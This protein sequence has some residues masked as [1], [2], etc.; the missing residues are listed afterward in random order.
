MTK[1]Q[2]VSNFLPFFIHSGDFAD[3][4]FHFFHYWLGTDNADAPTKRTDPRIERFRYLHGDGHNKVVFAVRHQNGIFAEAVNDGIRHSIDTPQTNGVFSAR[5][6]H[7]ENLCL[8]GGQIYL[9][10]GGFPVPLLLHPLYPFHA[11]NTEVAEAL[12]LGHIGIEIIVSVIPEHSKGADNIQI[13][14]LG[15]LPLLARGVVK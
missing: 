4:L 2:E 13:T 8:S 11:V 12:L 3:K 1:R 9:V 6:E 5:A 7:I 10:K 14:L 15:E